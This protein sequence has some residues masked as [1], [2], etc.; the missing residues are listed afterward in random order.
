MVLEGHT[1]VGWSLPTHC[2]IHSFSMQWLHPYHRYEEKGWSS[3]VMLMLWLKEYYIPRC[4]PTHLKNIKTQFFLKELIVTFGAGVFS[5]PFLDWLPL[6]WN[7]DY[8]GFQSLLGNVNI[9]EMG[10]SAPQC[11]LNPHVGT[12]SWSVQKT[13]LGLMR[14]Y[15]CS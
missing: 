4:N 13:G 3:L 1:G 5:F 8:F 11:S 15:R 12:L 10:L 14:S 2:F 7:L 6:P 9:P